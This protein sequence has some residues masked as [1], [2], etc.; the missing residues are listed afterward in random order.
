[1]ILFVNLHERWKREFLAECINDI[2]MPYEFTGS[3]FTHK[4]NDT[5]S[6]LSVFVHDRVTREVLDLYPNVKCIAAR[7]T[8]FDNIDLKA[9]KERGISVCNVPRYGDNTV[10]EHTFALLLSLSRN[11]RK[12]YLKALADDYTTKDLMGFD[13]KGKKLGVVGTGKIGLRVIKIAKGFSMDVIAS[14]VH[15]DE[16]NADV[17]GFRYVSLDELFNSSDIMSLHA[18]LTADTRHMI[19]EESLKKM[20]RGMILINTSRGGLVH[21]AALIKALDDGTV[22][23]AGLDVLE[24]EEFIDTQ[25]DDLLDGESDPSMEKK[26][27]HQYNLLRR[28]NVVFTPHVAFNSREAIER[29][30]ETTAGNIRAYVQG[31]PCNMVDG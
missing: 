29:I 12:A 19:N 4:R 1:M 23:G 3:G 28:P 26:M 5:V 6:I 7:S 27:I 31:E 13:L 22:S 24:Y 17:L 11:L 14:D 30:L 2:D 25:E 10:A 8:G 18:P 9:C 15:R 20:K 21:T 16:F